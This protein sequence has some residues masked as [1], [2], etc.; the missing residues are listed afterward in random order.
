MTLNFRLIP[1]ALLAIIPSVNDVFFNFV[2]KSI[3]VNNVIYLFLFFYISLLI[4]S[5]KKICVHKVILILS[6]FYLYTIFVGIRYS[7]VYSTNIRLEYVVH[8]FLMLYVLLFFSFLNKVESK[9]YWKVFYLSSVL[10]V[11]VVI[12]QFIIYKLTGTFVSFVENSQENRPAAFFSEPAHYSMLMCLVLLSLLLNFDTLEIKQSLRILFSCFISISLLLSSSSS[13]MVY[14]LFVWS[15]WI[16]KEKSASIQIKFILFLFI[17]I[18]FVSIFL[19]TEE[20][21]TAYEHF[22]TTDF[23]SVTSGSFRIARGFDLFSSLSYCEKII[24]I[25]LGNIDS[26]IINN[27]FISIYDNFDTL[28]SNYVS[29]LSSFF[30]EGGILGT[31]LLFFSMI[32][33]SYKQ[34]FKNASLFICFFLLILSNEIVYSPQIYYFIGVYI[35]TCRKC[36]DSKFSYN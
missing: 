2:G 25:G 35:L 23:S 5:Y 30:L 27:S 8:V 36:S 28:F 13:G 34:Q 6:V 3:N 21:S 24:G 26:Y 29:A 33:F 10:L 18:V 22:M 12:L 14:V 31:A 20:L 19:L 4:L 32:A 15:I 17:L 7:V 1:P 9:V 16:F 11:F